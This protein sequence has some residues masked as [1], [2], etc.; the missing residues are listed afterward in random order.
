MGTWELVDKPPNAIPVANKW[1]FIRKRNKLGE[2]VKYKARLVAK[3]YS[4]RPG[5]DYNETYSPVIRLD[6]L[7]AILALVPAKR[8]KVQQMDIKGAYLNGHLK[9]RVYMKQPEGFD[10]GTGRVCRLVKT[11]YGLKQSGREWNSE[12]NAKL[13]IF[14]FTR[15]ISDPCV[16]IKREG[17]KISIIT[18]WVDDLLLFASDDDLMA[19]MKKDIK[20]CW[21]ATDI[22]EPTKIVGIEITINENSVSISPQKY[23]ENILRQ[24]HM[25]DAD[26]VGTPSDPNIQL[27]PNTDGNEGDRS[28][29]YARLVGELQWI[30]NATRPDIA[31]TVNKLAA[32]TANPS[33]QHISALK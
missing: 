15:L 29:S 24:E 11:L 22:G 8:L 9:E 10:D 3:G 18:V 27:E 21:E 16:Y 32:Y 14:G 7:R 31:Y 23:I 30:A 6:M 13:L 4:Q 12:L 33:L 28:N 19:K 5:Q 20:S 1:V 2:I 25:L 26:S 17:D